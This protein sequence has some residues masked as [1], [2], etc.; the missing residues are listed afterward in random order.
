VDAPPRAGKANG[1]PG[2]P[3]DTYTCRLCVSHV[4]RLGKSGKAK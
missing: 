2:P 3:P 4:V 1:A